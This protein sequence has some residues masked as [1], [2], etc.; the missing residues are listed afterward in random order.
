MTT[1]LEQLIA[2]R[3]SSLELKILTEHRDGMRFHYDGRTK[4]GRAQNRLRNLGLLRAEVSRCLITPRGLQ[5][6]EIANGG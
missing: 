5:V 6:L 1:T 3:I 4:E 2:R